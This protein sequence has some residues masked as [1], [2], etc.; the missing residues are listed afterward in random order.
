METKRD[1]LHD[2]EKEIYDSILAKMQSGGDAT[3][4]G[5]SKFMRLGG[6]TEKVKAPTFKKKRG[7]LRKKGNG[8]IMN[9]L[10]R[11]RQSTFVYYPLPLSFSGTRAPQSMEHC[12]LQNGHFKMQIGL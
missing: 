3:T 11:H 6:M 8:V 1:D 10:D 9:R 5:V 12:K 7:T 2:F 4:L